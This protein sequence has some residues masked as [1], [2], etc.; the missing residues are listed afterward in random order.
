MAGLSTMVN[1][2]G[3]LGRCDVARQVLAD[4]ADVGLQRAGR[5]RRPSRGESR[6]PAAG[7][8]PAPR[9]RSASDIWLLPVT[10]IGGARRA[11][12]EPRHQK[13]AG[14]FPHARGTATPVPRSR[15]TL[16]E[17]SA[18]SPAV[19]GRSAVRG[20]HQ[21]RPVQRAPAAHQRTPC[22]ARMAD[23]SAGA[24]SL[25]ARGC[26]SAVPSNQP[27]SP[28]GPTQNA[29]DHRNSST[30]S[31]DISSRISDNPLMTSSRNANLS[32]RTSRRSVHAVITSFLQASP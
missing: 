7:Q 29:N 23:V 10:G 12:D 8:S 14:S 13:E 17:D 2:H 28:L 9:P 15:V 20:W 26:E 31:A 27:S 19:R 25:M 5:R 18:G 6:R 11:G 3:R 32:S 22:P 4:L 30:R 16:F 1:V 24:P 21:S